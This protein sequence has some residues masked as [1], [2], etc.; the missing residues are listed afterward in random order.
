MAE[1]TVQV[2]PDQMKDIENRLRTLSEQVGNHY[3]KLYHQVVEV[4]KD[5]AWIGPNADTY[6]KIMEDTLL[7]AVQRLHIQLNN[8][9][10][11]S[12]KVAKVI[13]DADEENKSLFP[14]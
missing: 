5:K 14:A 11:T 3:K 2:D 9:S 7:P 6:V 1:D 12:Q 10:Q 13:H 4:L 8:A